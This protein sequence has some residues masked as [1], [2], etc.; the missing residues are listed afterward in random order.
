MRRP[1]KELG[2]LRELSKGVALKLFL[3]PLFSKDQDHRRHAFHAFRG[4]FSP[5]FGSTG[6]RAQEKQPAVDMTPGTV[7]GSKRLDPDPNSIL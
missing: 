7:L 2:A 3:T 5:V 1:V 4:V 6:S